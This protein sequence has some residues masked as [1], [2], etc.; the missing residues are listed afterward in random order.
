LKAQSGLRPVVLAQERSGRLFCRRVNYSSIPTHIRK[1]YQRVDNSSSMGAKRLEWQR[2]VQG[3]HRLLQQEQEEDR[4]DQR[5]DRTVEPRLRRVRAG[6]Q[7]SQ[8]NGKGRD[9]ELSACKPAEGAVAGNVTAASAR[10]RMVTTEEDIESMHRTKSVQVWHSTRGLPD[11]I[12]TS[13]VIYYRIEQDGTGGG[14]LP[15]LVVLARSHPSP[16]LAIE[17]CNSLILYFI[18]KLGL[19]IIMRIVINTTH[20]RLRQLIRPSPRISLHVTLTRPGPRISLTVPMTRGC[21]IL[22][23]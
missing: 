10:Y 7:G 19:L 1:R 18:I 5:Q 3:G 8:G 21:R 23:V 4:G 9:A 6:S 22:Y 20:R 16:T 12:R 2:S 15:S 13:R 11:L 14:G 17:L